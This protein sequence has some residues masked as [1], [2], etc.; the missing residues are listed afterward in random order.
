MDSRLPPNFKH[1]SLKKSSSKRKRGRS[2]IKTLIL[3][4]L[5]TL[6]SC[7]A[8]DKLEMEKHFIIKHVTMDQTTYLNQDYLDSLCSDLLLGRST[9]TGLSDQKA[10]LESEPLV[11][12]ARLLRR[13]PDRIAVRVWEREPVALLNVGELLPVDGEGMVLPLDLSAHKLDL[14]IL[15]PRSVSLSSSGADP[16]GQTRIDRDGRVLLEALLTFREKAPDLL[17]LVSEFTLD[18]RGKVTVVTMDWA[19]QVVMGKWVEP[20]KLEYLRWMLDQ[21][22]RTRERPS[23]VDLSFEGQIIVKKKDKI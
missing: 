22:A 3:L 23:L 4:M 18:E 14:P 15:T 5:A 19:M 1:Y 8:A 10:R 11:K 12:K 21:L 17:P 20:D 13:F 6:V 9:L 7:Y 2:N 16:S